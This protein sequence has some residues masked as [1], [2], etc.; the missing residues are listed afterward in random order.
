MTAAY[1]R[2]GHYASRPEA[3]PD[4]LASAWPAGRLTM[5]GRSSGS[6][7][8]VHVMGGGTLPDGLKRSGAQLHYG[9]VI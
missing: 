7:G 5:V 3:S 6:G 8:Q 1:G 4:R 9:L 2:H